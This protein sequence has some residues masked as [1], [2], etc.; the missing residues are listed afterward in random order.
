MRFRLNLRD[1]IALSLFYQHRTK[2]EEIPGPI[3]HRVKLFQSRKK[4]TSEELH[5][6]AKQIWDCVSNNSYRLD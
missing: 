6:L 1:A 3:L 5:D 2:G 4:L